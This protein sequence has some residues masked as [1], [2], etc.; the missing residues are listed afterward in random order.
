MNKTIL[1][2]TGGFIIGAA[3]GFLL[4][5]KFKEQ[6]DS[7]EREELVNQIKKANK[8]VNE[9][10]VRSVIENN[11]KPVIT[12]VSPK[13][14]SD[15]PAKLA[16]PEAP[17][18]NYSAYAKKIE[19]LNYQR[20]SLAPT[21]GDDTEL[22]DEEDEDIPEEE[23]T[24]DERTARENEAINEECEKYRKKKGNQIDVLGDGDKP[25]D[26]DYPNVS[27]QT[28]SLLYFIPDD[29]V[30]DM[31]GNRIDEED[32]LGNKLRRFGW[33]QKADQES[34]WV[35]NNKYETDYHI[36]KIDDDYANYDKFF[37]PTEDTE[38]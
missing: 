26:N 38:E 9:M 17:G 21:D 10:Q 18:V 13:I 11:E 22:T 25:I 19:E 1:Y 4:G 14:V 35:R 36:T 28:E 2:T 15:G 5:Y 30:T 31:V 20:G 33:F 8:T 16:T 37:N 32:I 6:E 3:V 24:Y 23:E 34:V 7:A 29:F 27:Y 12:D